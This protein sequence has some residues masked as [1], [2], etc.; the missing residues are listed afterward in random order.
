MNL[1]MNPIANNSK[2][3]AHERIT[4]RYPRD[5]NTFLERSTIRAIKILEMMNTLKNPMRNSAGASG[6][7][8]HPVTRNGAPINPQNL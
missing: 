3:I 4:M 2:P 1:R 8:Y 6:E 7:M 5:C